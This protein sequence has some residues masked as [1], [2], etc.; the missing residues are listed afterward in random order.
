MRPIDEDSCLRVA[1]AKQAAD[2]AISLCQAT[3]TVSQTGIRDLKPNT[4]CAGIVLAGGRSSRM[5]LPK[6]TLPFGPE[7]ML[8][9]VVRLLGSVVQPIAVVAARQQEL[10]PL[11]AGIL[12]ARDEREDRGPLEGLRA[13]LTAIA[14]HAAAG[15]ATTC[16]V[17]LLVPA[18]VQAMIDRLEDMQI[19]VPVENGFPHPLAAVYRTSVL[20]RIQE[21]LAEDR[22]RPAFLFDNAGTRRVDVDEVRSADPVL[23]TLRNLNRPE[24]YLAALAEAGLTAD[25]AT[26]AALAGSR[27]A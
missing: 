12:V 25:P 5:G 22:L 17:P 23:A 26:M 7:L 19:A 15:Y 3:C 21:L 8:Q 20:P 9:R 14:P 1:F 24:D 4:P 2:T 13:G 27:S 10:P 6:A 11:P 18:F 16:D